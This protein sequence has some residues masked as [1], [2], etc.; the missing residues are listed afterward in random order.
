LRLQ[1]A[2]L[3][4]IALAIISFLFDP[5]I[6]IIVIGV[7]S[8]YFLW[9]YGKRISAL[10]SK[11]GLNESIPSKRQS[12]NDNESGENQQDSSNKEQKKRG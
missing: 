9:I 10:E 8:A 1:T 2:A 7:G 5:L 3:I 6:L 12:K 11:L 4:F